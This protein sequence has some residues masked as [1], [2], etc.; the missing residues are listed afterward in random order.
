MSA[1]LRSVNAKVRRVMASGLSIYDDLANHPDLYFDIPELEAAL[2]EALR[3]LDLHYPNRTK[4]KKLK[5]AACSALGYPIPQRFKRAKPKFPGQNFDTYIL[6][7]GNLQIYNEAVSASRR[8]VLIRVDASHRVTRV[9]V[10]TGEAIVVLDPAGTLTHKFQAKYV[11]PVSTSILVSGKDSL[12]VIAEREARA[13]GASAVANRPVMPLLLIGDLYK[14][15]QT[16][17]GQRFRNPGLSRERNRGDL[18]HQMVQAA[19][20]DLAH[21]DTGQFPDVPHQLLELKLQTA[22]TVD[23]GLVSP[24]SAEPLAVSPSLRHCDVR[25]GIFYASL[26][27]GD[28]VLDHLVLVTGEDFFKVF[29]RFEGKVKNS[30]L[31]IPLPRGFFGDTE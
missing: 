26:D 8:Y 5:E 18:L 3:G 20:G 24:D 9:R 6:K 13:R 2:D 27:S 21:Q 16:L 14:R 23:L 4:S 1:S 31:Q 28:V 30:K 29:R 25:Y 11:G 19:L 10:V 22:S 17:V 15:L 7:A 12:R